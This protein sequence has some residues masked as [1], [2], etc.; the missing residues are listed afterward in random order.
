MIVNLCTPV[1][2]CERAVITCLLVVCV[3]VEAALTAYLSIRYTPPVLYFNIQG[4]DRDPAAVKFHYTIGDKAYHGAGVK[5]TEGWQYQTRDVDLNGADHV[6]VHAVLYTS[7]GYILETTDRVT[8]ELGNNFGR[9]ALPGRRKR[10]A[11]IFRDNFN[12]INTANW[13]YEISMFG[14]MNWEFQVYTTEA[15]NTFIRDGEILYIKPTPTTDDV[16]F[17]E[18]FLRTGKMDM[19]EIWGYCTNSANYGCFREGQYGLLPPIMS[20]KIMSI[21]TLRYGI[22]E[23]RA[24]IPK[25]DWIWPGKQTTLFLD[26]SIY[27]AYG[28]WPRSGAIQI[29]ESRGEIFYSNNGDIGVGTVTSTLHWGPDTRTNRYTLTTGGQKS[30]SWH[31]EFHVYKLV[32]TPDALETFVD[33]VRIMEV[34][35]GV[36]FW[37]KGGFTG[38][39]IWAGGEKMAPFDKDFYLILNV[40]V[41]G[42]NGYFP[43]YFNY[44]VKKPWANNSPRAAED[45]WNARNDWLPTWQGDETAMLIDY[46]E[47]R[48]L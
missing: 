11:V 30:P 4:N 26:A 23:V 22:V 37:E 44:G 33:D 7:E 20:G 5:T 14:G 1:H 9:V 8:L 40:A 12:F 47:F 18:S 19:N 41:G 21:P 46:V 2:T 48:N 15:R 43:D 32:W 45:F 27:N 25:G 34:S 10:G 6:V 31:D 38:T 13:R 16:R 39:N 35:P 24:K 42:V 17:S 3:A 29:M 36:N 28:D